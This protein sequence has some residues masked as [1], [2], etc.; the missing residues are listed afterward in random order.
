[1]KR[2]EM[3]KDKQRIPD[4]SWPGSTMT[5]LSIEGHQGGSDKLATRASEEEKPTSRSNK[6]KLAKNAITVET[7]NVRRQYSTGKLHE[8]CHE[9]ERYKWNVLGLA[10]VR[11]P[12]TGEILT[13]EGH[14]IWYSGKPKKHKRGVAFLVHKNNLQSILECRPVSGRLMSIRLEATPRSITIM[15]V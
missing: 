5:A 10:E 1:M 12:N 3:T 2:D 6:I 8:L 15:Q 14:K 13:E 4:R 11:W 7:W 9:M